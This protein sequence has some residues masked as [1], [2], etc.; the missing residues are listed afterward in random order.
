MYTVDD[1]TKY[2]NLLEARIEEPD[3]SDPMVPFDKKEKFMLNLNYEDDSSDPQD[4][5]SSGNKSI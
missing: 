5:N 1:P 3:I 2:Q 4:D